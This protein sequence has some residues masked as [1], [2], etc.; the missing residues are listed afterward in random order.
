MS[1]KTITQ[2]GVE[3]RHGKAVRVERRQ[4]IGVINTFGHQVVDTRAF[5]DGDLHECMS[6][7]HTRIWLSRI[8]P[9]VGDVFVTNHRRPIN[10]VD[11]KPTGFDS[12]LEP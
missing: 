1:A 12:V 5:V 8:M 11:R 10:G 3:A 9:K 7:E 6:M 2:C 4:V